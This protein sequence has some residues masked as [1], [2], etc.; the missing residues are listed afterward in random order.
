MTDTSRYWY[1]TPQFGFGYRA[2]I[3]WEGLTVDLTIFAAF[4]AAGLWV[5]GH[6]QEHPMLQLGFFFGMLA[7]AVAIRHWKGEPKSWA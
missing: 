6:E 5:R 3:T 4:V 7:A 2:P 1:S